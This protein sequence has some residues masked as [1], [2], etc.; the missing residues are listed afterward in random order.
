MRTS[1][2]QVGFN[3]RTADT[4]AEFC[5]FKR[6]STGGDKEVQSASHPGIWPSVHKLI[7]TGSGSDYQVAYAQS[8]RTFLAPRP[9][10]FRDFRLINLELA[11]H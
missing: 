5:L 2:F 7:S 10:A 1:A 9:N 11:I 8:S 4:D 6:D 3:A